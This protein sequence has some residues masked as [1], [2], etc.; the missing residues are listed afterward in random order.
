MEVPRQ[1]TNGEL[2]VLGKL[3]NNEKITIPFKT[4]FK[5]NAIK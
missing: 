1:E 2:G 5:Y 4:I 3:L